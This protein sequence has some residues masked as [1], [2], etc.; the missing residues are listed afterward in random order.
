LE[1]NHAIF[2]NLTGSS[3]YRAPYAHINLVVCES[4]DAYKGNVKAKIKAWVDERMEK[5]VRA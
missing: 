3:S 1:H 2:A 4:T 5:Q